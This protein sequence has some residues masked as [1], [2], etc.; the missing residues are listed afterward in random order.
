MRLPPL[1]VLTDRR[2]CAGALRDTVAAA[3][4]SGARAVVL[5]EKDLP[6]DQRRALADDLRGLLAPVGG[7][8]VV[9]GLLGCP[10]ECHG[11]AAVHLAAHD[12]FPRRRPSLVGRSC[13][14][15]QELS[16]AIAQGCDYVTLSP[17]FSSRSKPGY[18][19]PLGPTGL[20]S[21]LASA[22]RAAAP[23]AYALGGVQPADVG[24]CLASGAFGVAVM[25]PAMRDPQIV[26]AYVA[27]LQEVPA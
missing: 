1:L 16:G 10:P 7:V 21:L 4:D 6:D 2:Q 12:P 15:A 3:V 22:A 27:A 25:G 14:D 5:R 26:A 24:T 18:G 19:P 20:T 13:H 23:P 11:D 8:L 17:V 9:A